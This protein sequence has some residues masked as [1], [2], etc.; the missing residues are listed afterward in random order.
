MLVDAPCSGLGSLA[1]R[2]DARWRVQ[3]GDGAALAD[4]QREL[5]DAAASLLA[6]GGRLVYS[7]CTMTRAETV[8]QAG[9]FTARHRALTPLA[10]PWEGGLLL[11]QAMGTDGMFLGGAGPV[12][13]RPGRLPARCRPKCSPCPMA[14]STAP[15]RTAPGRPSSRPLKPPAS[16]WS[17]TRW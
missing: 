16:R 5:L 13:S 1:R 8:D 14:W 17:T 12:G 4:L 11:P 6:P 10:P 9:A 15:A 2:P 3:A 7:V